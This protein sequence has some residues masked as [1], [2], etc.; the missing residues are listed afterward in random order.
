MMLSLALTGILRQCCPC[1]IGWTPIVLFL[2]EA[3]GLRQF[4]HWPKHGQSNSVV[5]VLSLVEERIFPILLVS[6]S[7]FSYS[8]NVY[9]SSVSYIRYTMFFSLL[10]QGNTLPPSSCS[11]HLVTTFLPNLQCLFTI[12]YNT[13]SFM[14]RRIHTIVN[15]SSFELFTDN[16][17]IIQQKYRLRRQ[18]WSS[19][20]GLV[21]CLTSHQEY[22]HV[23][24]QK[25]II[26]TIA[27]S[28]YRMHEFLIS[29][30]SRFHI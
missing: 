10:F 22:I 23:S 25:C 8:E 5:I 27:P 21:Q 18:S 20:Q 9:F 14:L 19:Q 17:N 15:I 30:G 1:S 29:M 4:W 7:E 2:G 26:L 6:L 28:A 12:Q 16:S 11:S 24:L 3:R 13:K